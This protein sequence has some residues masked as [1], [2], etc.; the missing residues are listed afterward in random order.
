MAKKEKIRSLGIIMNGV[1]GRMGTNQHLMRSIV[2]I[3][4]QGGIAINSDEFVVPDPILIGRNSEKLKQVAQQSGIN[5]WSTDLDTVLQDDY[6]RIYFDAQRTGLRED[7]IKKAVLAGKH[8]YC[9]KPLAVDTKSAM[10]LYKIC[11]EAGVKHGIVQDKLWLPGLIKLRKLIENGFFG[12]ILSVKGNFGYWVFDGDTVPAQRPSWN[13]RKEE[14][15]GIILDMMCHWRYILDNLFGNVKSVTCLGAIHI[16]ERF[17]EN[18]Q[19]YQCTAEDEAYAIF[20]LEGNIIA[21][22]N[23]SWNTRV[24]RDDLLV[25][26]VDGV[27]GSAVAGLQKCWTQHLKDTPVARWN[28]DQEQ[29]INFYEQWEVMPDEAPYDNAFKAQWELFLRHVLTDTPFKWNLKEGVKGVQLAEKAH[30]SWLR[31]AWVEIP[32]L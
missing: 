4:K 8:I 20:Q 28:P 7:I 16:P 18:G 11:E 30:E 10:D 29:S 15:G 21:Q 24:R 13:Y 19:N 12:R 3:I 2:P 23:F 26:Q 1:T 5:K 31:K 6:Y 27:N 14:N 9:E 22:F 17:D 32:E 25:I